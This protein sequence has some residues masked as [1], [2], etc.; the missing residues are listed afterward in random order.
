MRRIACVF[1]ATMLG[2]LSGCVVGQPRGDVLATAWSTNYTEDYIH[3]FELQTPSGGRLLL[4]GIQV[5][6]FSKGGTGSSECCSSIQGVGQMIKVVWRIS[7]HNDDEAQWKTYS[8][9]VIVTGTM[10][11]PKDKLQ[12]YLIVRFFP[13]HEVE[14]E[15]V[16]GD[17]DFGPENPRVDKLFSGRRVMRTMGE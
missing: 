13:N 16:P 4:G 8:R 1:F 15:L 11:S 14:A 7:R 17:G 3:D 5:K 9:D 2:M 10:P 6:E 12:S